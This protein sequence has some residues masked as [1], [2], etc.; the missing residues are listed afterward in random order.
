MLH[1]VAVRLERGNLDEL[2]GHAVRRVGAADGLVEVVELRREGDGARV[3][4]LERELA[5]LGERVGPRH[6]HVGGHRAEA[7]RDDAPL[8]QQADRHEGVEAPLP[9]LVDA[10]RAGREHDVDLAS[11]GAAGHDA[12]HRADALDARKPGHAETEAQGARDAGLASA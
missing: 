2:R 7:P 4:I 8:L 3:D 6:N 9:E 5:L 1:Q 10:G 11:E 12:D